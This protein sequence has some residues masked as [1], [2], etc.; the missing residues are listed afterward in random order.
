VAANIFN[1]KGARVAVV[2]GSEI[3]DLAGKKLYDLRGRNIYLPTGELV[4]HMNDVR[5]SDKH[6]ARSTD[7]LFPAHRP[8]A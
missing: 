8:V 5:G 1:S 3:Y 2:V 4:G 7:R 6:L